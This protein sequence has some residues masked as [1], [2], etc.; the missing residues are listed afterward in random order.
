MLI[1]TQI[2]SGRIEIQ[3]LVLKTSRPFH[4]RVHLDPQPNYLESACSH[5]TGSAGSRPFSFTPREI[6]MTA[7]C[8]VAAFQ[9]RKSFDCSS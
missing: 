4:Y 1:K 3:R 2:V 8:K 5:R 9:E 6:V 7:L